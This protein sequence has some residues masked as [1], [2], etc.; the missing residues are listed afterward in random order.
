MNGQ[1]LVAKMAG[2][3]INRVLVEHVS[4][5]EALAAARARVAQPAL[6]ILMC[7]PRVVQLCRRPV[8]RN[9]KIGLKILGLCRQKSRL[10]SAFFSCAEATFL[11]NGSSFGCNLIHPVDSFCEL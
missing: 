1:E 7:P 9:N 10:I 5:C 2:L 3:L 11:R 6:P 8:G 4:I